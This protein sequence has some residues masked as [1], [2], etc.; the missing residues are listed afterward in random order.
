MTTLQRKLWFE[1]SA[2]FCSNNFI[3]LHL[4]K[5]FFPSHFWHRII[6]H[7]A[8]IFTN[9][10]TFLLATSFA[11]FLLEQN[12]SSVHQLIKC[13][14][15]AREVNIIS[16]VGRPFIFHSYINEFSDYFIPNKFVFTSNQTCS[17]F[18]YIEQLYND[19]QY[20]TNTV[21]IIR[22]VNPYNLHQ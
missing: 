16:L 8:T 17:K 15:R 18:Q 12:F 19:L 11:L 10:G 5:L 7:L 6:L 4:A 22:I 14:A 2:K 20:S 9:F 1:H 3:K 21:I 13:F